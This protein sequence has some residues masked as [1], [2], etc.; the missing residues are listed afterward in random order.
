MIL[1]TSEPKAD[2]LEQW[3]LILLE[4]K[5]RIEIMLGYISEMQYKQRYK[6]EKKQSGTRLAS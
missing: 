4:R 3:R 1:E 5:A 2:V 6:Q